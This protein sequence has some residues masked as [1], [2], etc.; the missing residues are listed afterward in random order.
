MPTRA[1]S[2]EAE[3][4]RISSVLRR[5]NR[6]FPDPKC[7]LDYQGTYQLLVAVI[8][9]AQCTDVRVNI[10]TPPL[11]AA[12]PDPPAMAKATQAQVEALVKSTGFFR[13]KA[14]NIIATSKR[15]VES[16]GGNVPAN[17]EDL[18]S[19][20]GVARKTANVVLGECFGIAEGVV[21]DTH[22]N[23]LSNLLSL[24]KSQDPKRI[25]KDLMALLPKKRW[26]KF[27][28]QLILHG[29][30]TCIARRPKCDACFLLEHCP[31]NSA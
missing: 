6:H 23:R 15:L 25:E 19:L 16:F 7:E 28:H 26:I 17:M 20:P 2:A 10:V 11:F 14:K 12:F 13:N 18:L 30:R 4:K 31:G 8:L 29:R 24:T 9:S 21:V 3:K 1:E 5:L 22:V 27:A